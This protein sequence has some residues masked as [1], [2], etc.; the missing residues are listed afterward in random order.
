MSCS[1]ACH[2]ATTDKDL[3]SEALIQNELDWKIV[4]MIRLKDYSLAIA[5]NVDQLKELYYS[6]AKTL[7][8]CDLK[9]LPIDN[10]RKTLLKCTISLIGG[11]IG[12]DSNKIDVFKLMVAPY[13]EEHRAF[14]VQFADHMMNV[15]RKTQ[16]SL[17]IFDE[18]IGQFEKVGNCLL[19]FG[20][21]LNHSC[22]P[23]IFWISANGKFVF[24]VAKPIRAG[25][26]L[27]ICYR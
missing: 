19:A 3:D 15:C 14:L 21:L 16:F 24:I 20:G 5:G 9:S 27:F 12:W 1:Q 17:N 10:L 26:Q 22:D 4:K 18:L 25:E 23:N 6:T 13:N 11:S 8:D 2:D 7:F